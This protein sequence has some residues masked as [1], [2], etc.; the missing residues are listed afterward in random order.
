MALTAW[1]IAQRFDDVMRKYKHILY[2][3][4]DTNR[5]MLVF[6]LKLLDV[7]TKDRYIEELLDLLKDVAEELAEYVIW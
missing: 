3:L 4:R 6:I 5:E 2:R 1:H 7:K